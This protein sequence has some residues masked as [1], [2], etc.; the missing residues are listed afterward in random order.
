M[1]SREVD[2]GRRVRDGDVDDRETAGSTERAERADDD[3][4]RTD[5]GLKADRRSQGYRSYRRVKAESCREERDNGTKVKAT[6]G[7]RTDRNDDNVTRRLQRTNN[8]INIVLGLQ[9]N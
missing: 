9:T 8:N 4:D 3:D 2:G 5:D 6:M 1:R 7:H